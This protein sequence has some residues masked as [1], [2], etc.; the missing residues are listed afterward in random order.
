MDQTQ[1]TSHPFHA[2]LSGTYKLFERLVLERIQDDVDSQLPVEQGGF[3]RN[4]G[5]NE[6]LL[7]FS[8]FVES[9][10][11]NHQ[12]TSIAQLDL[13]TAYGTVWKDGMVLK[14]AKIITC[15]KLARLITNML[16]NRMF[17]V[18]LEDNSSKWKRLNSG[19]VQGSVLSP[20][21]FNVYTAGMPKTVCKKFVHPDDLTLAY[22]SKD[23]CEAEVQLQHDIK[24][25]NRY[26]SK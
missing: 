3:R 2:L 23:L 16:S 19:L 24:V 5:C 9:G 8:T 14:F 6:Q 1:A 21:L 17:R 15:L 25:M 10:F 7:A 26:Y 12:K 22:Q 11:H 13:T 20:T 4:R 18:Y